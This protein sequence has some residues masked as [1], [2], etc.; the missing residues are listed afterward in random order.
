MNQAWLGV[1]ELIHP[2]ARF[3]Y[4]ANTTLSPKGDPWRLDAAGTV[5]TSW[6]ANVWVDPLFRGR[7]DAPN[8]YFDSLPSVYNAS[9]TKE[10]NEKAKD[11]KTVQDQPYS[12]ESIEYHL[13][14]DFATDWTDG[15]DWQG[16][17]L[18]FN[19]CARELLLLA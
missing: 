5:R 3:F 6:G 16:F 12:I 18:F 1:S 19:H 2:V 11:T 14:E 13:L 15:Q 9:T 17:F 10:D 4:P 8:E 7:T